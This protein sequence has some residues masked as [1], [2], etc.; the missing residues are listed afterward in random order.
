[1]NGWAKH[2]FEAK[3]IGHRLSE[4]E[5]VR[6]LVRIENQVKEIREKYGNHDGPEVIG[7]PDHAHEGHDV[8][9][10]LHELAVVHSADAG[11]ESQG[12]GEAGAGQP[13]T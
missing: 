13:F 1:M 9:E 3:R 8:D 11:N 10:S 12:C 5:G 4:F 7:H 2:P 6:S